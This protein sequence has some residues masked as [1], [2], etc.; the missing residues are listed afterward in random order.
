MRFL[1]DI[2]RTNAAL[3]RA[4][5]DPMIIGTTTMTRRQELTNPIKVSIKVLEILQ[6]IEAI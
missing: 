5:D 3:S 1:K 2:R 6:E 4:E